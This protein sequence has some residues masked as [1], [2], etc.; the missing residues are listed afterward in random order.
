AGGAEA[1]GGHAG[2]GG[3]EQRVVAL[4]EQVDESLVQ[5]RDLGERLEVRG[6]RVAA[7][8]LDAP[9]Q[10]LR[11]ARAALVPLAGQVDRHLGLHAA[12]VP[13]PR[14]L[15]GAGQLDLL[16]AVAEALDQLG[17]GLLRVGVH[18]IPVR[19]FH[20]SEG[21]RDRRL[22]GGR[23][24][25]RRVR[26]GARLELALVVGDARLQQQRHVLDGAREETDGVQRLRDAR[27]AAARDEPARR[28]QPVDAAVGRGPD[29]GAARLAAE[30]QRYHPGGDGGGR[31]ARGSAGRVRGIVRIARLARG[32]ARE[33]G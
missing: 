33:L 31:A 21:R 19:R 32:A 9:A 13:V 16:H 2:G 30:G 20:E 14:L 28:L 18:A 24:A 1:R 26:T 17:E 3:R 23:R 22:L 12:A 5:T 27:H 7:A 15:D 29:R 4:L 11:E 6:G 8:T 10:P 25:V